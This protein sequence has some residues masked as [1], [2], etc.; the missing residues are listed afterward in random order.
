MNRKK[1][2]VEELEAEKAAQQGG[3]TAVSETDREAAVSAALEEFGAACKAVTDKRRRVYERYRELDEKVDDHS[4]GRLT[5][6]EGDPFD[7]DALKKAAMETG[8][9]MEGKEWIAAVRAIA[10]PAYLD[11]EFLGA[12]MTVLSKCGRYLEQKDR[13]LAEAVNSLEAERGRVVA[14]YDRKIAAARAELFGH[15]DRV[16]RGIIDKAIAADTSFVGDI[17]ACFAGDKAARTVGLTYGPGVP[18][19]VQL[20]SFLETVKMRSR[21]G[22]ARDPYAHL[23]HLPGGYVPGGQRDTVVAEIPSGSVSSEKTWG[24]GSFFDRFMRAK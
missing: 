2:E 7:L 19:A 5:L 16:H 20:K 4:I 6:P 10:S 14:E 3:K 22:S 9:P 1:N 24:K 17:P 12:C 13:Q 15:R 18:V 8:S 11:A 23:E 21:S